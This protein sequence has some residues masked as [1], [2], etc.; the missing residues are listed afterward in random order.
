MLDLLLFIGPTSDQSILMSVTKGRFP[1]K[2]LLFFW[3]H[4]FFLGKFK[5]FGNLAGAKHLTYAHD[6]KFNL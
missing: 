3:I 5:M 2:K 4:V 6:G 1:E